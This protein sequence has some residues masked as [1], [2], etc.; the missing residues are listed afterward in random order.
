MRYFA[1]KKSVLY[2]GVYFFLIST[3]ICYLYFNI[4]NVGRSGSH[5]ELLFLY[6]IASVFFLFF[7]ILK[8]KLTINKWVS[9]FALIVLWIAWRSIHDLDDLSYLKNITIATT[10]GIVLFMLLG[11]ALSFQYNYFFLSSSPTKKYQF[12]FLLFAFVSF[13]IW[14]LFLEFR[15][16]LYSDIFYMEGVNDGYQRPGNFLSIIF[17]VISY[18]FIEQ[19]SFFKKNKGKSRFFLFQILYITLAGAFVIVGQMFGSN[20]S[21]AVVLMVSCITWVLALLGY[22]AKKDH[23]V[24]LSVSQ[25]QKILKYSFFVIFSIFLM[26]SFLVFI[27][28][29]DLTNMRVFGFGSGTLSSVTSRFEILFNDFWEQAGY[30]PLVGNINVAYLT[31]GNEG[32]TLH[33]FIPYVLANLGIIGLVLIVILFFIVLRGFYIKSNSHHLNSALLAN[34][35]FYI[36]LSLFLYANIANDISWIVIWFAL[37]FL[38]NPISFK[39]AQNDRGKG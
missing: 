26:V 3:F 34:N 29:F 37:G 39:L 23:L 22:N 4:L 11:A 27:L 1:L 24:V 6:T 20:S 12:F 10:G 19:V 35:G 28:D 15:V 25:T 9:I 16:R 33:S 36:I 18:F 31:T 2:G 14:N 8:Q 30:S 21:T 17:I 5:L 13:L 7:I 32:E 38:A